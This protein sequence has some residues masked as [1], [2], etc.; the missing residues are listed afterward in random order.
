MEETPPASIQYLAQQVELSYGT[1]PAIL[2]KDL[3]LFPYRATC[4]QELH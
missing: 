3:A 2:T 4:V 1:C